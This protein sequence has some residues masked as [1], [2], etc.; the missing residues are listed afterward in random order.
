M[1]RTTI[2]ALAIATSAIATPALADSAKAYCEMVRTNGEMLKG[3]CTW[4]QMQGNVYI[5]HFNH[6]AFAFP[7]AEEGKTYERTNREGAGPSFKRP[8]YVINVYW[9]KPVREPG[10]I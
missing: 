6:Y 5:D 3:S 1:I 7:A 4:S 10:G 9:E 2:T 8:G